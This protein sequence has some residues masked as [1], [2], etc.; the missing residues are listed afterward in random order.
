[1]ACGHLL[2]ML[3]TYRLNTELRQQTEEVEI[4]WMH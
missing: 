2:T 3:T 1:M 4:E